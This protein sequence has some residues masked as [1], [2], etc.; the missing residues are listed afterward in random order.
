MFEATHLR[1]RPEIETH[2]LPDGSCLLFDPATD[3]GYALN[4]AGALVWDYC[5]G[6]MTGAE[7]SQE[8]ANLLPQSV[9]MATVTEELLSELLEL[10]LIA[11][12]PAVGSQERDEA[13][14]TNR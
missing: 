10:G 9:D 5:D 4:V 11:P 7:V 14:Q 8:L 3:K 13:P 2:I 12:V 1:Q 6:E